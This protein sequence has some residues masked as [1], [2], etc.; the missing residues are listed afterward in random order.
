MEMGVFPTTGI[1]TTRQRRF[2]G[3]ASTCRVAAYLNQGLHLT[4]WTLRAQV[5]SLRSAA[6]EP[7]RW[8]VEWMAWRPGLLDSSRR[9][10]DIESV[11]DSSW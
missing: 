10:P 11:Y 2:R 1:P 6:G 7:H 8:A 4:A 3:I 5:P 9:M